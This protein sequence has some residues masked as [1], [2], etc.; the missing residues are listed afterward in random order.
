MPERRFIA[1][2]SRPVRGWLLR[3]ESDDSMTLR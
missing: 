3:R 2:V 1:R